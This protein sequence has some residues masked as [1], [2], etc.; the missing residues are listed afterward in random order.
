MHGVLIF[1]SNPP[2]Q[3][4]AVIWLLLFHFTFKEA[5]QFW[6]LIVIR[7]L[8]L[9]SLWIY[10]SEIKGT[11]VKKRLGDMLNLL[12]ILGLVVNVIGGSHM[13]TEQER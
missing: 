7:H 10:K 13:I 8:Y 2:V 5:G 3:A 12:I 4:S 11:F 9:S 1:F 6:L